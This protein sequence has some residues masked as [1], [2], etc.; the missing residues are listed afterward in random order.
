MR[1]IFFYE[2]NSTDPGYWASIAGFPAQ[3]AI[4]IDSRCIPRIKGR[5]AS[6]PA[7]TGDSVCASAGSG[8][9]YT[10]IGQIYNSVF[11]INIL[12]S[13]IANTFLTGGASYAMCTAEIADPG[14]T[15]VYQQTLLN[16]EW[17]LVSTKWDPYEW[18]TDFA[19]VTDSSSDWSVPS[20]CT[21]QL[22]EDCTANR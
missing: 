21:V 14:V 6:A 7:F 16:Q 2:Q 22:R 20:H 15:V 18:V 17:F 11:D 13:P 12:I 3:S 8:V 5:P 1:A 10:N 4:G 19:Y 9:R